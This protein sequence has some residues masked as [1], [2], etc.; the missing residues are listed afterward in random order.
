MGLAGCQL[1]VRIECRHMDRELPGP[2]RPVFQEDPILYGGAGFIHPAADL[3]ALYLDRTTEREPHVAHHAAVVPPV[4]PCSM[5]APL[6]HGEA[7][8]GVRCDAIID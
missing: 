8:D 7:W 2:R 1:V 6:A 3:L 4:V 5:R